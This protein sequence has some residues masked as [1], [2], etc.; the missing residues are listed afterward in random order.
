VPVI[1]SNEPPLEPIGSE[2]ASH[3]PSV[4]HTIKTTGVY[5]VNQFLKKFM[6]SPLNNKKGCRHCRWCKFI[7]MLTLFCA[8][9]FMNIN[10]EEGV[11]RKNTRFMHKRFS[12]FFQIS[13]MVFGLETV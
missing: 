4:G 12:N 9:N 6:V 10:E 3:E 7:K 1:G 8:M 13:K 2:T 11:G 5:L